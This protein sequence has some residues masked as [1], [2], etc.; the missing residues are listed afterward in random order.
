MIMRKIVLSVVMLTGLSAA[1]IIGAGSF[2][3]DTQE[4]NIKSEKKTISNYKKIEK[5]FVTGYKRVENVFVTG[6][7]KIE[8]GVVGGYKKIENKFVDAL[9]SDVEEEANVASELD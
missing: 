1:A 8:N 6:Y 2:G 9:L 3:V 4:D 7:N 5:V